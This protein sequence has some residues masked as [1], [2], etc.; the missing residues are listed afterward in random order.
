VSDLYDLLKPFIAGRLDV[1]V[2]A[3]QSEKS[4]RVRTDTDPL[5]SDFSTRM[6]RSDAWTHGSDLSQLFRLL[7]D[8]NSDVRQ[9]TKEDGSRQSTWSSS[10]D[11]DPQSR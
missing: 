11:G 1:L 3:E 9:S 10:D 4:P 6:A 5:P 7:E 8:V 2:R